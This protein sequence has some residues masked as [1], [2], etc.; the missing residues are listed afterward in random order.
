MA[1]RSVF[2]ELQ[3]YRDTIYIARHSRADE[4]QAGLQIFV[5]TNPICHF[6]S[7]SYEIER[8]E[9][10]GNQWQV[11]RHNARVEK[12]SVLSRPNATGTPQ[13]SPSEKQQDAVR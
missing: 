3:I 8:C 4:M 2:W 9:F 12:G 6:F 13:S 10:V 7:G 5:K 1:N 11:Q